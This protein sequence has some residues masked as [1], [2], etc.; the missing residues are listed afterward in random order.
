VGSRAGLDAV[1][2]RKIP[3]LCLKIYL[4]IKAKI[5]LDSWKQ[6]EKIENFMPDGGSYGHEG[7]KWNVNLHES[8]LRDDYRVVRRYLIVS[9]FRVVTC[10]LIT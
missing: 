10:K 9:S 8:D 1:M 4:K 7:C 2:N 6:F 5:R 3:S